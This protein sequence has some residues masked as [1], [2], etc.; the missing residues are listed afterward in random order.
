MARIQGISKNLNAFLDTIAKSEGTSTL[1][2]SDDGYDVLVGERLFPKKEGKPDYSDHPKIYVY[3]PNLGIRSSASGRYQLLYRFYLIYKDRLKLTDFSPIS[4]DK[5]AIQQIKECGAL[6]NI[7][8]NCIT[9]AILR[10]SHIW[11]S[12]EGAGYGQ[13]ENKT[14]RLEEWFKDYGGT[15]IT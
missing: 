12:F 2:D 11:A 15:I 14:S 6:D 10:V 4:Q 3:L 9:S 8:N 1:K 7:E 13:H 5:I